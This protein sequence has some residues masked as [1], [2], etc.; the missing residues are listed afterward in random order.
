VTGGLRKLLDDEKLKSAYFSQNINSVLNSR[1]IFTG[2]LALMA[3]V[4]Y[5]RKCY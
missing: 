1:M 4:R 5:G 3:E 2:Y